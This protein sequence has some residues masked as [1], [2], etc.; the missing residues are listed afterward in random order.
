[1]PAIA[2]RS[3]LLPDYRP[4]STPPDECII[5]RELGG[6]DYRQRLGSVLG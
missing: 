1:M 3:R 2:M 5:H 6:L 4:P